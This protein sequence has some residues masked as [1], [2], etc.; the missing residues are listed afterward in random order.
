MTRFMVA[1]ILLVF[2]GCRGAPPLRVA[3]LP[4]TSKDVIEAVL[5]SSQTALSDSTCAEVG[6]ETSDKTIGRY[7]AGYLAEISSQDARNA[8]TTTVI[9]GTEDGKAVYVCRLMIRHAKEEDVW[10]WGVQFAANKT[11]GAVLPGSLRC[12]G[13]G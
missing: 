7:L 3:H 8:V 5:A 4:P 13:A 10:S 9:E 11:D 12:I 2:L 6:T 1:S